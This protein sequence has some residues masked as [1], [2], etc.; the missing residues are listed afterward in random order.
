[1]VRPKSVVEGT[2]R[3]S[4]GAVAG[5]APSQW[6][7]SHTLGYTQ[8][9]QVTPAASPQAR[10]QPRR[11]PTGSV[12]LYMRVR[13]P[14][15]ELGMLAL[16][17][18]PSQV[19]PRSQ[20]RSSQTASPRVPLSMLAHAMSSGSETCSRSTRPLTVRSATGKVSFRAWEG[21]RASHAR[22]QTCPVAAREGV[23]RATTPASAPVRT[24]R[25]ERRTGRA[26]LAVVLPPRPDNVV[27]D[28]GRRE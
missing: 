13:V 11:C 15:Q 21:S 18:S 5:S 26:A 6:V 19:A 28:R 10:I 1:M 20:E 25:S 16:P 7:P 17:S 4:D 14:V 23:G 12:M 2:G 24:R 27:D 22:A 8:S 9:V 3:S